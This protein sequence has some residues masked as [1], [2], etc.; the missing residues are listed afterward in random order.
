[1]IKLI[2]VTPLPK[3]LTAADL[4][5]LEKTMS[6]LLH[7]HQTRQINVSF[8]SPSAIRK[9]NRLYRGCDRPTDILSFSPPVGFPRPLMEKTHQI[10]GDLAICP[11]VA[12]KQAI[13]NA[14]DPREEL[15]RLVSH[16]ILHLAGHDHADQR[17]AK[18]MFALQ[19][20]CTVQVL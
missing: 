11:A 5:R 20:K 17:E 12:I 16:G 6:N 7:L 4:R 1:M 10:M 19:E 15:L 3:L 18:R 14:I 9:L 8:V 13:Q 2:V